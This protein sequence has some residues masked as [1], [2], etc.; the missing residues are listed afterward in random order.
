MNRS[1]RGGVSLLA[2]MALVSSLLAVP[3][4]AFAATDTETDDDTDT[5]SSVSESTN[6]T[7]P[8]TY[9]TN[10]VEVDGTLYKVI[11]TWA[12]AWALSGPDYIGVSNSGV[13]N[14]SGG[15][16][17]SSDLVT[18]QTSTMLGIWASSVNEVPNAYN[19]NYFYNL[20]LTADG[21][22]AD[23]TQVAAVDVSN[24]ASADYDTTSGVYACF[25][26]RPEVIWTSN[27]LSASQVATYV[28]EINSLNYYTDGDLDDSGTDSEY[29]IDGDEDYDPYIVDTQRD[30]NLAHLDS[31][32]ELAGYCEL[33]EADTANYNSDDEVTEDNVT[34][35]NMNS[36]PRTTRYEASSENA[37]SARE[38][39]LDVEKLLKGAVYYTLAKI[40]DGTT[41][42]KTVAVVSGSIDTTGSTATVVDYEGNY[43]GT[44][45]DSSGKIGVS[46]LAIDCLTTE[47][48]T[49]ATSSA[50]GGGMGGG[51][52]GSGGG[53]GGGTTASGTAYSATV[54]ELLEADIIWAADGSLSSDQV[55]SWLSD[56]VTSEKAKNRIGTVEII[57]GTPAYMNSHN[58]TFEKAITSMYDLCCFYPELWPDLELVT[59]WYDNV[60]HVNYDDLAIC[61]QYGLGSATMPSSVELTSLPGSTYSNDD[62]D[63]KALEGYE[64]YV[65]DLADQS[66][67]ADDEL[68]QPTETYVAWANGSEVCSDGHSFKTK[69]TEPTCTEAGYTTY[70]CTECGFSYDDEDAPATGHSSLLEAEVPS[71]CATVGI[72]V[73]ECTVCGTVT[74][75]TTESAGFGCSAM[76]V[77]GSD[78]TATFV[79]AE[80]GVSAIEAD[81]TY[82]VASE[83]TGSSSGVGIYVASVSLDGVTYADVRSVVIEATGDASAGGDQASSGGDDG[84]S[85]SE[86]DGQTAPEGDGQAAPEGDGQAA[87][88]NDGQ[89]SSEGEGQAAPGGDGQT[90]SDG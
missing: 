70:T 37:V 56:N 50:D 74:V 23:A 25:K 28:A 54:D 44:R 61:L 6:W 69:V 26:Y 32:Y 18:A 71:A 45:G 20:A 29:Y 72:E 52:G 62:I 89:A 15:G 11:T 57:T 22:E 81:V 42:K 36:L 83:A 88:G 48:E 60:Y 41:E 33:I 46:A 64:Y 63:A 58:F 16:G 49:T 65:S 24:G 66:P 3:T 17:G 90:A 21:E 79:S 10:T 9:M 27:S 40:A 35:K 55:M 12:N 51:M 82:V 39:A 67:Y 43:E 85:V 47:T 34:W 68:L 7:V 19:W 53:M 13:M 31:L 8:D 5:S 87:S 86:G 73:Y 4:G 1:F 78:Y 38:C 14:Q 2:S 30:S 59:Y 84:Q 80:A 77:W 75:E 76:F